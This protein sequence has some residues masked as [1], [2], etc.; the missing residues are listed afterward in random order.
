[1]HALGDILPDNGRRKILT[2]IEEKLL[3]PDFDCSY[4]SLDEL[5][6]LKPFRSWRDYSIVSG[7]EW[8]IFTISILIALIIWF[9]I[10]E[11]GHNHT[12]T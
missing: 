4:N 10:I 8:S 2:G 9:E 1:M 11:I 3:Q 5:G 7:A 12:I 6:Q